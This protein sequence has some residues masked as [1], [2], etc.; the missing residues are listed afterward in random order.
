[1][2]NNILDDAQATKYGAE[3][4]ICTNM[5]QASDEGLIQKLNFFNRGEILSNGY[6]LLTLPVK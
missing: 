6:N 5:T 1:L 2:N 3:V 4:N